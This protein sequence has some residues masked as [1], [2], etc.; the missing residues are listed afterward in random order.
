[1]LFRLDAHQLDDDANGIAGTEHG[2]LQHRV[3]AEQVCD[4]PERPIR[5]LEG[6]NGLPG[7]DPQ[8]ADGR[9]LGGEH[10]GHA[11]GEVLVLRA[12]SQVL[13]RQDRDGTDGLADGAHAVAGLGSGVC[14]LRICFNQPFGLGRWFDPDTPRRVRSANRS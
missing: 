1:M 2:S 10:F 3:D 12:P 5:S 11:V 14:R 13:Q 9:Q 4:V 6:T 7:D 8:G